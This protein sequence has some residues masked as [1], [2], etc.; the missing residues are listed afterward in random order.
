ML[1]KKWEKDGRT[2]SSWKLENGDVFTPAYSTLN[3]R[4]TKYGT[5]Y[6]LKANCE[7]QDRYITLTQT[8]AEQLQ[9]AGDIKGKKVTARGYL[10]KQGKSCVSVSVEGVNPSPTGQVTLKE[11]GDTS[12]LTQEEKEIVTHMRNELNN[13]HKVSEIAQAIQESYKEV[14]K[15]ID[16]EKL[17]ELFL[18]A[19][20]N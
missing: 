5:M 4:T 11:V 17:N 14:G 8:Q 1:E 10:N 15:N 6:S 7:G 16:N 13:G 12:K 3:E 20:G 19:T 9:K 2:G 18:I